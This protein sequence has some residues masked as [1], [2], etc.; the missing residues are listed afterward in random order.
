MSPAA[1]KFDKQTLL[2]AEDIIMNIA[3][4]IRWLAHCYKALCNRYHTELLSVL[5]PYL[6]Q[7]SV[8]IDIGAHSGQFSKLFSAMVPRGKVFGFEPGAY[9]LSIFRLVVKWRGLRN[10]QIVPLGLSDAPSEQTLFMPI[11]RSGAFG[12]GLSS[13]MPLPSYDAQHTHKETIHLTTLD[14]FVREQNITRVDLIKIDIEGWELPAL[15][16]AKQTIETFRPVVMVEVDAEHQ[17]R[18]NATPE[19]IFA[20]FPRETYAVLK[21]DEHQHYRTWPVQ[22]FEGGGDYIFVPKEKL[23]T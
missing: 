22:G 5:S 8:I 12:F 3:R 10:V 21:T 1:V 17:Q 23:S 19:D 4:N 13:L 7:E 16:G 2:F 9:A 15:K 18:A 20:L 6:T 11:K 14:D